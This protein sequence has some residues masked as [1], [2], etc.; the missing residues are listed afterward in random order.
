MY[1]IQMTLPVF[2]ETLTLLKSTPLE[3]FHANN[4]MTNN[5]NNEITAYYYNV[6]NRENRYFRIKHAS[7]E[8]WMNEVLKSNGK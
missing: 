5:D 2:N 1:N 8:L 6:E 3:T 4:L 7:G